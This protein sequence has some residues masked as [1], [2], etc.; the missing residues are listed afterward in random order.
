MI[1]M[2]E[3]QIE[4]SINVHFV[5]IV[6]ILM[7]LVEACSNELDVE[8]VTTNDVEWEYYCAGFIDQSELRP[9]DVLTSSHPK[10]ET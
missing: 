7:E 6:H 10:N 2:T 9:L 4:P 1:D 3:M 8:D 5:F